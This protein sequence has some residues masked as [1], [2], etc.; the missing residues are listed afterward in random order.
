MVTRAT[1]RDG[2]LTGETQASYAAGRVEH[3]ERPFW[4]RIPRYA[5]MGA[6]LNIAAWTS[7]WAQIGPSHYTFFA[8]WFGFILVLDGLNV[9]RTGTSP[10]ARSRRGFVAMFLISCPFW[11][12]FELLNV[13]V[14]NWHYILDQ[15]YST[16]AYVLIASLNFST[17]L[18]AVMEIAEL[19]A[20]VPRLRPRLRPPEVGPRVSYLAAA[21]WLVLG[22]VTVALPFFFPHYAYGLIWLCLAFLLD[23]INNLAQRKSALGHLLAGDWRFIVTVPLAGI[24]CGFFWE[25]WNSRALPKWYYTVPG[26]DA[27]PHLFAMPIPGYLGYLP[28]AVELFAM[29]QFVLL[30]A[31][32]V[33]RRLLHDNLTI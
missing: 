26:L 3:V 4:A 33:V 20:T 31:G 18:P 9:A 28:F 22:V 2:A 6:A 5:Y 23:P 27:G 7:S 19:L 16:L 8:I 29:Y 17:V 24:C 30:I 12:T 1:S 13:P 15:P 32:L 10:L 14:Q 25:M 21:G 11:W